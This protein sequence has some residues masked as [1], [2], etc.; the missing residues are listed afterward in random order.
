[1]R[2]SALKFLDHFLGPADG[3]GI[4]VFAVCS[5]GGGAAVAAIF[6]ASNGT[7]G[8]FCCA[9]ERARLQA[10][11]AGGQVDSGRKDARDILWSGLV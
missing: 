9:L 6:L 10:C 11:G 5:A 3:R 7:G 2:C 8:G 4:S 1:M